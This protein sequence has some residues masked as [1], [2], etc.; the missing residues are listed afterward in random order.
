QLANATIQLAKQCTDQGREFR[1]RMFY[2][3]AL[4]QMGRRAAAEAQLGCCTQLAKS[5]HYPKYLWQVAAA[6]AGRAI[7]RGQF[8]LAHQLIEEAQRVGRRFDGP[9]ADAYRFIQETVLVYTRGEIASVEA[10]LFKWVEVYPDVALAHAALAAACAAAG[11]VREAREALDWFGSAE[12]QAISGVF[13]SFTLALLAEAAGAVKDE[14]RSRTL[15]Q[16]LLLKAEE[17]FTCSYGLGFVLIGLC[18]F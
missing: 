17:N 12:L 1:C 13:G 6:N 15:Y 10:I 9:I 4:L 5:S 3:M 7:T 18:F 16:M 8:D 2:F 11:H 14:S